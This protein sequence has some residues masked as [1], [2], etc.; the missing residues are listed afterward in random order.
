[1]NQQNIE[2]ASKKLSAWGLKLCFCQYQDYT[3]YEVVVGQVTV[4]VCK[5][6]SELLA[7]TSKIDAANKEHI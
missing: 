4:F 5:S 2:T 3:E 7:Y 6:E 1:M